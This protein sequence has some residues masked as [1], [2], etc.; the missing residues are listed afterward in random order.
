[1]DI[2]NGNQKHL[3]L[4]STIT[5]QW[6]KQNKYSNDKRQQGFLVFLINVFLFFYFNNKSIIKVFRRGFYVSGNF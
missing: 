3:G 5:K 2:Y 1:M 6:K 4:V